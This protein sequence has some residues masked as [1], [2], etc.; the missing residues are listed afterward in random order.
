MPLI[1]ANPVA[2]VANGKPAL[3]TCGN[4]PGNFTGC[5]DYT[6]QASLCD[7]VGNVSPAGSVKLQAD[8]VR[9]VA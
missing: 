5:Q 1:S 8:C 2:I 4:N 3:V 6:D 9:L 7:Q